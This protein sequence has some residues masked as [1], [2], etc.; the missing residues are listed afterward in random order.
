M[1]A[2]PGTHWVD[3]QGVDDMR[4]MHDME[5][6][7][8]LPE[9]PAVEQAPI[10]DD[11]RHQWEALAERIGA[12][13][14]AY[15][16]RDAPT[17]SRRR[18]RR[19]MRSL[20]A[21]EE[22]TR[23]CGRRTRRPSGSGG[24]FSTEFAPVDHLE[25][26]LSLDNVFTE[27]ELGPGTSG[28]RGRGRHAEH[29][30]YLCELKIDGLAINLSTKA[31][32]WSGPRPAGTAGRR[33]RHAQ[34]ANDRG[35]PARTAWR[36]DVPDWWRSAAR[37]SSRSRGFAELNAALVGPGK[38]P[39]ANPRNTA[40]GSLRQRTR[41]SPQARAAHARPRHGARQGFDMSGSREAY[42][43]LEGVGPAGPEHYRV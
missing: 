10:S 38:A 25:R 11:T 29:G 31:A 39:F 14:F 4:A 20:E 9:Q 37:S 34:R 21:L 1:S 33:G 36:R 7:Q 5:A 41:G 12:A 35:H 3:V 43:L 24:T 42:A 28:S 2:W 17:I 15:Y 18:V 6:V 13:Q 27:E 8:D 40:A 30:H 23:R 22:S 16:V 32:A 26:M 19:L